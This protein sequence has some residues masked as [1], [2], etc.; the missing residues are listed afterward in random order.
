M[1]E[2]MTL[3]IKVEVDSLEKG[4]ELLNKLEV[5]QK[6]FEVNV[7]LSINTTSH[8]FQVNPE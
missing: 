1:E 2:K 5:L 8:L 7:E 6:N 3:N 4:K